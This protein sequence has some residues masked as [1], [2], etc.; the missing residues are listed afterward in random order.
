M[1]VSD[2]ILIIMFV[3]EQLFIISFM[4]KDSDKDNLDINSIE[5]I[6][7]SVAEDLNISDFLEDLK[8]RNFYKIWKI[9]VCVP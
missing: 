9:Y 1:L 6:E 3:I 7:Y 8:L 2:W 4:T 5:I